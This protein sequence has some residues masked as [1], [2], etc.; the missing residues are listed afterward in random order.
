MRYISD[1]EQRQCTLRS[2]KRERDKYNR[3][4]VI[5]RVNSKRPRRHN[6]ND[7]YNN[8]MAQ[9]EMAVANSKGP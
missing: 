2:Y 5:G 6:D 9:I 8:E 1:A 4:H 7:N 3:L